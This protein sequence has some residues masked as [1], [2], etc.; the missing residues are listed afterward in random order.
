MID[1]TVTALYLP[2]ESVLFPNTS[3]TTSSRYAGLGVDGDRRR[4]PELLGC[5]VL[6]IPRSPSSHV[7]RGS[8][9]GLASMVIAFLPPVIMVLLRWSAWCTVSRSITTYYER[10]QHS[11]CAAG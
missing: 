11:I 10:G 1:L 9:P 6:A 4:R 8:Y 7:D 2:M 5:S 3:P